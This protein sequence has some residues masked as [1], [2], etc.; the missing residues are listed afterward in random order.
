MRYVSTY[1][2]LR[3][4]DFKEIKEIIKLIEINEKVDLAFDETAEEVRL[5]AKAEFKIGEKIKI[6]K[7][8]SFNKDWKIEEEILV[9]CK[10]IGNDYLLLQ[11]EE[12]YNDE[13]AGTMDF[14]HN[15]RVEIDDIEELKKNIWHGFK[16]LK[17]KKGLQK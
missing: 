9:P 6:G 15:V 1:F 16:E 10:I 7:R 8:M 4:E 11:R 3:D 12:D 17:Y 13:D 5:N 2:E 14:Y